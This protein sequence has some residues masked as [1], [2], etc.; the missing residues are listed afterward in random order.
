METIIVTLHMREVPLP[1]NVNTHANNDFLQDIYENLFFANKHPFFYD[2]LITA[3]RKLVFLNKRQ[4]GHRRSEHQGDDSHELHQNIQRRTRGILKR[5]SDGISDNSSLVSLRALLLTLKSSLLNILLGVIPSTSSVG[6]GDGHL[7]TRDQTS[8]KHSSD[9]VGSE[10]VTSDQRSEHD[11]S[12]GSNHLL[13]RGLSGNGDAALVVGLLGVVHDTGVLLELLTD[14]EDHL[15][16]GLTDR[17]HGHGREPVGEHGTDDQTSEGHGGQNVDGVNVSTGD[18]GSEQGE[19]DQSSGTNGETLTNSS[20]GV[21][22]GIESVSLHTD[23]LGESA[24]LSNTSSVIGDGTV[25]INGETSGQSGQHTEGSKGNSV[26]VGE[27]EGDVDGDSEGEHGDD[28]GLVSESQTE[29]NVGGSSSLAGLRNLLDGVVVV[30][31]HV[32]SDLTDEE[33]RPKTE[34][35]APHGLPVGGSL[36]AVGHLSVDEGGHLTDGDAE[37]LGQALPGEENDEHG[38]EDGGQVQLDGEVALDVS[39]LSHLH[40]GNGG[41]EEGGEEGGENTSSG[42]EQREHHV[43]P[44]LVEVLRDRGN[45][46]SSAGRLSEGSEQIGTHSSDITDVITDVIGND[47]R[48][49]RIILRNT[50]LDL[51]DEI[52]TDISS[53]SVDTTTHTTEQGNGGTSKSITGQSLEENLRD[54]GVV[55]VPGESASSVDP[56]GEVENQETNGGQAETHDGT[57]AESSVESISPGD[58]AHGGSTSVGVDGNGHTNVTADNGSASTNDESN[59]GT[60]STAPARTILVVPHAVNLVASAGHLAAHNVLVSSSAV[61]RNTEEDGNNHSEN[62]DEDSENLVFGEEE[63][64]GTL[65]NESLDG[66]QTLSNSIIGSSRT[67]L[68][69]KELFLRDNVLHPRIKRIVQRP[70]FTLE[71]NHLW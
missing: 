70:Y 21:T 28:D 39:L 7:H 29:N 41:G 50:G 36:Q 57:G 42:D 26:H 30:G 46:Q 52:S 45:D 53:L 40:S 47:G 54:V 48:V 13:Q 11:Q 9:G 66:V 2:L 62:D 61:G 58:L 56:D 44:L 60:Q 27:L 15:V 10:D 38:G 3:E 20:G 32:V 8:S 12:T 31:G 34:E 69:L 24:H 14:L 18:E 71:T 17:L 5:I 19:G 63:G 16:G 67:A 55:G 6:S 35:D 22:G 49:T 33:T 25:G 37:V 65:G 4:L 23:R 68:S 59:G 43:H 64:S 51:S 1:F